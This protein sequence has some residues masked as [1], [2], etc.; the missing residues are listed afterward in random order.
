MTAIVA[1]DGA[2]P[3]G[4]RQSW[5]AVERL[6]TKLAPHAGW[7]GVADE[8]VKIDQGKWREQLV[9]HPESGRPGSVQIPLQGICAWWRSSN[10]GDVA[11]HANS[12]L[13]NLPNSSCRRADNRSRIQPW[14]AS[15]CVYTMR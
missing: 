7:A 12:S 14:Q 1:M 9:R 15:A 8:F 4:D 11:S 13:A 6:G 10:V 3:P 5:S 2:S